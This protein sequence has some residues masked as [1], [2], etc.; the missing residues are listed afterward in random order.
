MDQPDPGSE[1]QVTEFVQAADE[2]HRGDLTEDD[3]TEDDRDDYRPAPVPAPAPA[4]ISRRETYE[5]HTVYLPAVVFDFSDAGKPALP[6]PSEEPAEASAEDTDEPGGRRAAEIEDVPGDDLE[7][8]E[9]GTDRKNT[10]SARFEDD[11]S[12][13]TSSVATAAAG[14][15]AGFGKRRAGRT[16]EALPSR[17]SRVP[18]PEALPSRATSRVPTPERTWVEQPERSMAFA[19]ADEPE[20]TP[21]VLPKRIPAKP[22]SR[23]P[24][25]VQTAAPIAP[26]VATTNTASNTELVP[27]RERSLFEPIRAAGEDTPAAKPLPTPPHRLRGA[28]ALQQPPLNS[29]DT[30]VPPGPFGPGSAMPLPGGQA[31]SGEYVVKASVTALRYCSPESPKFDRTVAEVWFRTVAE[32]ERVGFRPLA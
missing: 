17:A 24:F 21:N 15:S 31:P 6:E 27:D 25:G 13:E 23:I 32:A 26:S 7:S 3:L 22:Q 10:P 16:P 11:R 9:S 8:E 30:F 14:I 4:P 2:K 28:R 29:V 1:G 20:R 12:G 18:T 5:P 19:Q